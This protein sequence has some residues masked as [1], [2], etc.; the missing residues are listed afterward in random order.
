MSWWDRIKV[1]YVF[2]FNE[3]TGMNVFM[4]LYLA[5]SYVDSHAAPC[6]LTCCYS[7]VSRLHEAVL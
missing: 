1:L 5:L 3:Q 4:L 2:V 6:A 7:A